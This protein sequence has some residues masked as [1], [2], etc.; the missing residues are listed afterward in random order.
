MS[1]DRIL[2]NAQEWFRNSIVSKH[3]ENTQSLINPKEFKINPFLV[4]YLSNFLTGDST[5]NSIAKALVYPRVLGS[6]ITTSFG[7]NLQTF[8]SSVLQG[9]GSTT[10]GIDIEFYDQLD[11]NRKKYCQLKLGPNTINKDDVETIHQ[12]FSAIKRLARQNNLSISTDRDLIVGVLY[13]TDSQLSAHYKKLKSPEYN[14]T[15]LT[16]KAFWEHLTGDADFYEDL[17]DA[18][19]S[20]ASETNF[21]NEL[22]EIINKLARSEEIQAL[23]N[24]LNNH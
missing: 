15:V 11:N 21:T 5:P 18:F 14:Y 9:F 4:G 13:G 7:S 3:I 1:K 22:D 16:G 17:I 2:E 8:I 19:A 23:S 12:H 20:I 10:S 24:T 6:S